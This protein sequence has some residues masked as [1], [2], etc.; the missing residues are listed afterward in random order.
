MVKHIAQTER[1]SAF[2]L[3]LGALLH[4]LG[5]I[6]EHQQSFHLTPGDKGTI[7]HGKLGAEAAERILKSFPDIS[8]QEKYIICNA[9]YE[10]N[11]LQAT[12]TVSQIL[13]EADRLDGLGMIGLLRTALSQPHL[14][15]LHREDPLAIGGRKRDQH[16]YLVDFMYEWPLRYT[17]WTKTGKK[18]IAQRIRS[19]AKLLKLIVAE[20][21]VNT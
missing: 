16:T 20:L 19:T 11:K 12:G 14:E 2:V 7:D 3:E 17:G 13:H 6:P 15:M 5:R 21:G 18:I 1:S 4:D 9:I 8:R 10:H